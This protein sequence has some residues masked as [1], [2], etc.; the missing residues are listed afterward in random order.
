MGLCYSFGQLA[1]VLHDAE[2]VVHIRVKMVVQWPREHCHW[3]LDR[4]LGAN[5]GDLLFSEILFHFAR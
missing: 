3:A 1:N 4:P 5:R 2:Y